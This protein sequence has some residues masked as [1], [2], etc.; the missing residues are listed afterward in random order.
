MLQSSIFRTCLATAIA[1]AGLEAVLSLPA[2]ADKAN[3]SVQNNGSNP[4]VELYVSSSAQSDW[5]TNLVNGAPLAQGERKVVRFDSSPNCFY[6][7][8]AVFENRHTFEQFQ[9]NVCTSSALQASDR[10]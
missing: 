5:G 9:V 1:G 2:I 4:I 8:R 6:D 3:F 7:F 10:R